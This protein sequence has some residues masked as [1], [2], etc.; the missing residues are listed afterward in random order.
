MIEKSIFKDGANKNLTHP[1]NKKGITLISLIITI[2]VMLILAGITIN[3]TI[4]EDGVI[5]KVDD[6][7]IA[8]EIAIEKENIQLAISAVKIK[9][10]ENDI[11]EF[12]KE[13]KAA[14]KKEVNVSEQY[15]VTFIESQRTYSV[16]MATETVTLLDNN[17]AG[18]EDSNVTEQ[19]YLLFTHDE[20]TLTS[21]FKGMNPD[22]L[23]D[24]GYYGEGDNIITDLVIPEK[25]INDKGEESYVTETVGT[26]TETIVSTIKTVI[27]PKTLK[28]IGGYTFSN[29][30]GLTEI[31]IPSTVEVIM[32]HAF[33]NCTS[34]TTIT[35]P[36]GV[37]GLVGSA[38]KGCTSLI[39]AY[40]PSTINMQGGG[41]FEGC[42]SNLKI[43]VNKYES[44]CSRW[45]PS[46]Y[47]NATVI[48]KQ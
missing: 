34:L 46:W 38:F 18:P 5:S 9:G 40:L 6:S 22:Y 2:I 29:W 7:K 43:Y 27:L 36:E 14:S 42:S 47:G 4:S 24:N 30:T 19:K 20:S 28:R 1:K 17:S 41:H 48:Y 37:K 26:S 44:E 12:E 3:L 39:E 8:Q 13:I 45:S 35:I 16:D 10:K 32:T 33:V 25:V 15:E 31:N 21:T 11:V 23:M